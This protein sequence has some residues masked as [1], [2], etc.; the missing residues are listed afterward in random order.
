[1]KPFIRVIGAEFLKI[2]HSGFFWATFIA[3]G[4]APVIGA[5]FILIIRDGDALAQAGA[6]A[7]KAR[8]M[9]FEPTWKSYVGM[10][11]QAVGVG[12][13][14]VFGFVASWV[15]GR[16]Y[17]DGTAKDLLSLPASRTT[18]LNA[19]FILYAIWSVLLVLSNLLLGLLLGAVLQLPATDGASLTSPL[20]DYLIT[21]VLTILAGVPIA[22]FA[23]WGKG[24]LTPLGFVALTLVFSQIVA[25]AGFG[26]Y[27]PWAIP[28]LYSSV[29]GDY[30]LQLTV[31]SYAVLLLTSLA[32]YVATLQYW[33]RADQT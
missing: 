10:L 27:F 22:F 19:K 24:Y 21:T 12:G 13:V 4:L 8:A 7:T 26:A 23:L 14:M 28:G 25:A 11:T 2:R 9:N 31:Y 30:K 18:I 5:V 16:E 32:G 17:S 3:F 29:G 6:L 33:N 15:F 1:M 20:A